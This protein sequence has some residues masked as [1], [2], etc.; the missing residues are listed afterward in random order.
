MLPIDLVFKLPLMMGTKSAFSAMVHFKAA[1][2]MYFVLFII[3]VG[4]Y[5]LYRYQFAHYKRF[6]NTR[7][8]ILRRFVNYYLK[9]IGPSVVKVH[10]PLIDKLAAGTVAEAEAGVA[11][12]VAEEQKIQ[13]QEEIEARKPKYLIY[14]EEKK[15]FDFDTQIPQKFHEGTPPYLKHPLR[16]SDY[17]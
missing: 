4:P 6:D 9:V 14:K 17:L 5:F 8:F 16:E 11:D 1:V 13:V 3:P 7:D 15:R 2:F 12:D 10:G